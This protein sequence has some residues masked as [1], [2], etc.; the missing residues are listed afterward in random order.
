MDEHNRVRLVLL[1]HSKHFHNGK[2]Y[3]VGPSGGPTAE[4]AWGIINC[5][6]ATTGEFLWNWT[7]PDIGYLGNTGLDTHAAVLQF[8]L[9][10]PILDTPTCT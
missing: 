1:W 2:A 7:A 3:T 8:G 6:N 4:C 5:F 9:T 10:T